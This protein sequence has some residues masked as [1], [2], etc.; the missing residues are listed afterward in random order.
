MTLS[1]FKSFNE[2]IKIQSTETV[3]EIKFGCHKAYV[4]SYKQICQWEE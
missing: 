4:E 2:E 3:E 1:T